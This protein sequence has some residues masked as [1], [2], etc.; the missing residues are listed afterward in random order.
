M[1]DKSNL[2]DLDSEILIYDRRRTKGEAN[3]RI[4]SQL[5]ISKI[6]LGSK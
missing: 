5:N 3:T 2:Y 4:N 1:K 6:V